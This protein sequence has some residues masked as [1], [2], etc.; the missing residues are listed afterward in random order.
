MGKMSFLLND[1]PLVLLSPESGD[2]ITLDAKCVYLQLTGD[3]SWQ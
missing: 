1:E 3:V 2:S